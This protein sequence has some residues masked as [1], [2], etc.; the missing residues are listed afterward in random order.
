[1]I[2]FAASIQDEQL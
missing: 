1:M 2:I